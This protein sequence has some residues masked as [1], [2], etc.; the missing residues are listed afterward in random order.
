M[1]N[2]MEK[3]HQPLGFSHNWEGKYSWGKQG[4]S[5]GGPGVSYERTDVARCSVTQCESHINYKLAQII[6]TEK[7]R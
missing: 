2:F 6:Q 5:Y 7:G 1:L 3:S 4:E